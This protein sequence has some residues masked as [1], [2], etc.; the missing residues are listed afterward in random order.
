[1]NWTALDVLFGSLWFCTD[2]SD[3]SDLSGSLWFSVVLNC[4]RPYLA[5][6]IL[7]PIT[8]DITFDKVQPR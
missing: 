8:F 3:L 7:H 4:A 5:G 2:L 6:L 1:M